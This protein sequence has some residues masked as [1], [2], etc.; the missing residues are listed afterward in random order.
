MQKQS[1]SRYDWQAI[2]T[3]GLTTFPAINPLELQ[4]DDDFY[5][6]LRYGQR[7]DNLAY[8]YLGNGHYWWVI[9]L[10]NGYK[11][12]FDPVLITGAIVRVPISVA[13]IF[14]ILEDKNII[15]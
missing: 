2:S 11:T 15:I 9:C 8:Q 13:R 1:T 10:L 3:T 14:K 7:I 6:K 4:S 12:P 5:V